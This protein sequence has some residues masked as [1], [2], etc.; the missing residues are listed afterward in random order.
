MGPNILRTSQV[1]VY[2]LQHS[3]AAMDEMVFEDE[4]KQFFHN[5]GLGVITSIKMMERSA[6]VIDGHYEI[7]MP[8]KVQNTQL[9]NNREVALKRFQYLKTRLKKKDK[10]LN[11]KYQAKYKNTSK[12]DTRASY[13]PKKSTKLLRKFGIFPIILCITKLSL[14][15]SV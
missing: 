7:G 14:E 2:L 13:D 3:N 4:V 1:D 12:R 10:D 15:R 8:W 11:E 5:N 9:P 6:R